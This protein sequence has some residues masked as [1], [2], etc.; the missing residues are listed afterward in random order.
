MGCESFILHD[1]KTWPL[2]ISG[3]QVPT[4]AIINDAKIDRAAVMTLMLDGFDAVEWGEAN[5]TER[6]SVRK[7][8]CDRMEK[9]GD[10]FMQHIISACKFADE[11]VGRANWCYMMVRGIGEYRMFIYYR[12]TGLKIAD[13]I[14]TFTCDDEPA[15]ASDTVYMPRYHYSVADVVGALRDHP[16]LGI[17]HACWDYTSGS[18]TRSDRLKAW[19][20]F[21][22]WEAKVKETW[23]Q[24]AEKAT[25]LYE[26]LD[27][28]RAERDAFVEAQTKKLEKYAKIFGAYV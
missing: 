3:N 19:K 2:H 22:K 4:A 23:P 8:F 9:V 17:Y 11:A 26:E 25:K 16:K 28:V 21:L 15:T 14:L 27:R 24:Y 10:I 20:A 5:P 12:A 7:I 1:E 18:G 6:R 13:A